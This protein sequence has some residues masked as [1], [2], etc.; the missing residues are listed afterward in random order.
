M[1]NTK[2]KTAIVLIALMLFGST[3]TVSAN[4][5]VPCNDWCC[6]GAADYMVDEGMHEHTGAQYLHPYKTLQCAACGTR[7]IICW[8]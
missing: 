7:R 3:L 8:P 5:P 1:K 4:E 6:P 2:R